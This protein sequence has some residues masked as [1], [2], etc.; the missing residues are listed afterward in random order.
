MCRL[1]GIIGLSLATWGWAQGFGVAEGRLGIS[2]HGGRVFLSLQVY[3]QAW[4]CLPGVLPVVP[5]FPTIVVPTAPV[6]VVPADP[7]RDSATWSRRL[8]QVPPAEELA[9]LK[10]KLAPAEPRRIVA[11]PLL[12]P[13]P[14]NDLRQAARLEVDKGKQ[15]LAAAAPGRAAEHFRRAIQLEPDHAEAHLL[16]GQAE[17]SRGRYRDAVSALREG[18]R[19]KPDW[20]AADFRPIQLYGPQVADFQQDL[21]QLERAVRRNPDDPGLR[22]LLAYQWWFSGRRAEARAEFR[23]AAEQAADADVIRRFLDWPD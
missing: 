7:R 6:V 1:T 18:L 22:F 14:E 13:P 19:L 16:L 20:P 2:G 5:A 9:I 17:M 10:P 3:R 21:E 8:P 11:G 23:R 12:A 15:A 4:S